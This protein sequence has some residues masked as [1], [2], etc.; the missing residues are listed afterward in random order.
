MNKMNFF[1][2]STNVSTEC[3]SRYHSWVSKWTNPFLFN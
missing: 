2:A 1:Y 3:E